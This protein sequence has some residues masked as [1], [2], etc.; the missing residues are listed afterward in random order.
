MRTHKPLPCDELRKRFII[1]LSCP[2]GLRNSTHDCV[3]QKYR[4]KPAGCKRK[5]PT[6]DYQF[7]HIQIKRS[8]LMANRVIYFL[9]TGIDPLSYDVDHADRN[10]LN[11]NPENL[12]LATRS[13]NLQNSKTT[14][15][16]TSGH[17]GVYWNKKAN[18][19]QASISINKR[20][21]HL[22]VFLTAEEAAA[23]RSEAEI[24]VYKEFSPLLSR[25][26]P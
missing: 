1:D 24:R 22:G 19:W 18:K 6:S 2:S 9:H 8:H 14:K 5:N 11:N 13:Q 20:L 12:R 21:V 25:P 16:N 10:P 7:Y 3:L 23:A 17:K 4:G 15:R 26:Q